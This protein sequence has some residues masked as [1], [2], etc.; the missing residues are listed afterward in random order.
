MTEPQQTSSVRQEPVLVAKNLMK[1]FGGV[2][3]LS[4][5]NVELR[6][7]EVVALVGDNGA[8]KSTFAKILCG[9]QPQDGGQLLVHG[10]STK[11]GN[12]REAQ[13]QGIQMVFQDLALCDNLDTIQNLFLGREIRTPWYMGRR[14]D[15]PAMEKKS[16]VLADELGV[17]IRNL[18]AP[19]RALS[20]GQRQAVAITRAVLA[21][22]KIVILDEPTAA[23]G[24][25]K[26]NKVRDTIEKLR[27]RG[28]A[29]L[30]ISHDLSEV[31]HLADTVVVLRLG[32]T[33]AQL[34]RGNYDTDELIAQITGARG[35]VTV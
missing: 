22:P 35:H 12:T 30:I 14:L 20:G 5:A 4:D 23:L 21:D 27:D 26:R 8:G 3:A 11:F 18:S 9:A 7:G 25:E 10:Q 33:T 19:I 15:R 16:R 6:A 2:V 31:Q 1:R 32:K 29:V 28:C 17:N 34:T 13:A 24:H